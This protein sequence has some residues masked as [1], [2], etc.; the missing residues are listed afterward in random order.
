MI[1]QKTVSLT[2]VQAFELKGRVLKCHTKR[3]VHTALVTARSTPSGRGTV[4][5]IARMLKS[6]GRKKRG[7]R[8][9]ILLA[10]ANIFTGFPSVSYD[11]ALDPLE[12][13]VTYGL[14]L[15]PVQNR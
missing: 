15:I 6:L 8:A 3:N 5:S 14:K 4:V 1:L 7:V 10:L 2:T 13:L 9:D 11:L 12:C